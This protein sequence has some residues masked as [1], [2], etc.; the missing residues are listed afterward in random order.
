MPHYLISS[1]I[2][3]I[4]FLFAFCSSDQECSDCLPSE[5][6]VSVKDTI[7][8]N[9]VPIIN[10]KGSIIETRF[11]T[12]SNFKRISCDTNS[13]AQFLR[14][15]PLKPHNSSVKYYDG[16]T[17]RNNNTYLGV[18]DLPIGKRDLHQCADAV[19]R[20]RADYLRSQNRFDE[21]KFSFNNGFIAEYSKWKKGYRIHFDGNSFSWKKKTN[22]SDSDESYWKYLEYVFSFAGTWSLEKELNAV[23]IDNMKIGDIFILGGSPG[24]A[25]I[26]VDMMKNESTGQEYFMLAQS[27]MPA[28]EIQILH[29]PNDMTKSPWYSKEFGNTLKTPEWN[30]ARTSLKRF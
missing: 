19:M 9:N 6:T 14:N 24:H 13:F 18:V 5:D 7:H 3:P 16:D 2:V 22:P 12:V 28:Q 21:I 30:F 10:A 23:T 15:L 4:S 1:L 29:N 26:V 8:G 27:Y 11:N 20:L 25:V 17:K